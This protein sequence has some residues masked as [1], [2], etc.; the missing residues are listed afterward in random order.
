MVTV[1]VILPCH[2]DGL[3]QIILYIYV[4]VFSEEWND[5]EKVVPKNENDRLGVV[6][7]DSFSIKIQRGH[8]LILLDHP[9]MLSFPSHLDAVVALIHSYRYHFLCNGRNGIEMESTCSLTLVCTNA[10]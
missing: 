7:V 3:L 5:A 2:R 8:T 10:S 9:K 4:F 6:H 1:P